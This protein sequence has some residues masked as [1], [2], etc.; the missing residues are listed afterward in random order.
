MIFVFA[1][2]QTLALFSQANQ[3]PPSGSQNLTYISAYSPGH[4]SGLTASGNTPWL[5][6]EAPDDGSVSKRP[7][8]SPAVQAASARRPLQEAEV[9]AAIRKTLSSSGEVSIKIVDMA[10]GDYPDGQLEF[11]LRGAVPPPLFKPA[12]PFFWR[13]HKISR[14]GNA[15]PVWIRVQITTSHQ[16]VRT[17]VDLIAGQQLKAD[18]LE[19]LNATVC[20]LL[21]SRDDDPQS[22]EGLL[23]KR[24]L[25]AGSQLYAD[26]VK[27]PPVV[28]RGSVVPVEALIGQADIRFEARADFAG[29]PGQIIQL[30]NTSSKRHFRGIVLSDG[31]VQV[32]AFMARRKPSENR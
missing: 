16:V 31:S 6:Q 4:T 14:D 9:Q 20:P 19:T 29:Y 15:I 5:G 8:I 22:Y 30:T 27:P 23:L 7:A 13:G 26:L 10:K 21:I 32:L 3:P 11:P 12:C 18:D 28:E 17:K 25:R 1:L 24:S 2:M